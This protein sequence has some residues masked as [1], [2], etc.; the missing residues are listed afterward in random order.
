VKLITPKI[1]KKIESLLEELSVSTWKMTRPIA[2]KMRLFFSVTPVERYFSMVGK[3]FW[4]SPVWR[5]QDFSETILLHEY[6]HWVIYPVS[7]IRSI[8]EI[9]QARKLLASEV[10]FKPVKKRYSLWRVEED[11]SKFEYGVEE[12]KFAQN[13]LGDYLV[14]L[15]IHDNY[16]FWW[17]VLFKFLVSSKKFYHEKEELQFDTSFDLYLAA[18]SYLIPE[19]K[20]MKLKEKSA[21]R[22]AKELAKLVVQTRAKKISTAF[23]LKEIVKI[24]HPFI[25]REKKKGRKSGEEGELSCPKCKHKDWEIVAYQDKKGKWVNIEDKD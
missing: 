4:Y 16:E 1:R 21:Q 22:K 8:E 23:A 2:P 7:L 18:Y 20:E 24:F 5:G 9:F 11:W 14:N 19:I 3:I 10:G 15:H 25:K 17:K 6:L 13:V 12:F